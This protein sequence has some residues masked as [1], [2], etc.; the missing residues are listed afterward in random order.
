MLRGDSEM[1]KN[2]TLNTKHFHLHSLFSNIQMIYLKTVLVLTT[3][4]QAEVLCG[5]VGVVPQNQLLLAETQKQLRII[6]M[7]AG[8]LI[9]LG[10]T[11]SRLRAT[12]EK[13]SFV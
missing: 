5:V 11:A 9:Y 12:V 10:Q 1:K 13:F 2:L 7:Y 3:N 4:K 6:T 8:V